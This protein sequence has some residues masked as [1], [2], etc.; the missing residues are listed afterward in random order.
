VFCPNC[1]NSVDGQAKFCAACG[2]VAPDSLPEV[3][4]S[5]TG[6]TA[7]GT[8]NQTG[9]TANSDGGRTVLVTCAGIGS[10]LWAAVMV[11]LVLFQLGLAATTKNDEFAALGYWN[12]VIVALY[13]VIGIGILM[14]KKWAWD[15]GTG[16]NT[17]NLLF[18]IYQL[19][20]GVLVQVLLLPIELFIMIALYVTK[21]LVAPNRR[22]PVQLAASGALTGRPNPANPPIGSEPQQ[23][24]SRTGTIKTLACAFGALV[25]LVGGYAVW[26]SSGPSVKGIWTAASS[27]LAVANTSVPPTPQTPAVS[28]AGTST[29]SGQP[30]QPEANAPAQQSASGG[31]E[32]SL[33][34][35]CVSG[36]Q[37]PELVCLSEEL[38]RQY[39]RLNK[40]YQRVMAQ[41]GQ[42]G[43]IDSTAALRKAELE[44]ISRVKS[45]CDTT[46]SGFIGNSDQH[47]IE[48]RLDMTKAR[49]DELAKLPQ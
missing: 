18:G 12:L 11:L 29:E 36:G 33:F 30:A 27:Q 25:V 10:F 8:P 34:E 47:R 48:C 3:T 1:G 32:G 45:E 46:P 13:V 26:M 2:T 19:T 15:W 7:V 43:Q 42:R 9:N 14:R 31:T 44:W 38:D 5:Q 37:K 22:S 28:T 16:S 4:P 39:A 49:A 24:R 21:S 6:C 41:Y 20:Q 23:I 17:L 35:S 40:E